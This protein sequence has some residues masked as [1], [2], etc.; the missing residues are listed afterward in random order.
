[1]LNMNRATSKLRKRNIAL[2]LK[3]FARTR[4]TRHAKTSGDSAFIYL[5]G[6][7][8]LFILTV[9]HN[10]TVEHL[11][12]VHNTTHHTGALNAS[13][14]IG[15]GYRTMG[16]HIANLSK[17]F[18]LK[19]HSTCTRRIH[20][21]MTC[22][23]S[24][25]KNVIDRSSIIGSRRGIRHRADT[26]K[27]AMGCRSRTCL[28]GFLVLLAWIAK[29]HMYINKTGD[30]NTTSAIKDLSAIGAQTLPHPDNPIAIDED[31]ANL[32]EAKSRI[33]G[34][35]ILNERFHRSL[36]TRDKSAPYE[37]KR[38]KIPDQQ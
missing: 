22:A 33:N 30:R 24:T 5:T 13:T 18:A 1:M 38:R 4:P 10:H 6:S 31:I 3:L 20:S 2:N 37:R 23:L 11:R 27:T 15:K 25:V 8:Q 29:V 14:I 9:A 28:D 35:N 26:G 19:P 34:T 32:I 21:T 7:D 12:V 17:R 36:P 16:S